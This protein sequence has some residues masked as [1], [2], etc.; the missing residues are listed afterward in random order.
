MTLRC[1]LRHTPIVIEKINEDSHENKKCSGGVHQLKMIAQKQSL[2]AE[3][4]PT[5]HEAE[6]L[7]ADID[8]KSRNDC[9][10]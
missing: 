5:H 9:N 3:H 1:I 4:E 7:I 8:N 6:L 10:N 2:N